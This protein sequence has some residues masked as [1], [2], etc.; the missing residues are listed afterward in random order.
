MGKM[1]LAAAVAVLLLASVAFAGAVGAKG[2]KKASQA[3]LTITSFDAYW[4][5]SG[6]GAVFATGTV[7]NI[8][9]APTSAWSITALLING[10]AVGSYGLEVL[11]PGEERNFTMIAGPSVCSS[12]LTATAAADYY[13]TVP[14]SNE[15]NNAMT[16]SVPCPSK[17]A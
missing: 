6:S 14:E 12:G 11:Q 10:Y 15:N 17:R 7:K 5:T 2:T 9:T 4:Y 1:G 13:N 8:G 3:D 16:K